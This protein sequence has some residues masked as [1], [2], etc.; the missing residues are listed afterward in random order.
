MWSGQTSMGD[1]LRCTCGHRMPEFWVRLEGTTMGH[2]VQPLCSSR[3]VPEPMDCN[4]TVLEYLQSNCSIHSGSPDCS[5]C[6]CWG[7]GFVPGAALS[8]GRF[9]F[10][11]MEKMPWPWLSLPSSN[12]LMFS[13]SWLWACKLLSPPADF[14]VS[15]YCME[16]FVLL[17]ETLMILLYFFFF[18][19]VDKTTLFSMSSFYETRDIFQVFSPQDL[20]CSRCWLGKFKPQ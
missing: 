20:D 4:Q 11:E 17:C 3:A 18:V 2:Q 5:S 1:P 13:F 15:R 8:D 9:P 7:A 19:N 6:S 12:V 10:G 14:N 16:M